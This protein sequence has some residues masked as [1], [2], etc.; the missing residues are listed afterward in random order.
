MKA[1]ATI[2]TAA[3]VTAL[4]PACSL[5]PT[6]KEEVCESFTELGRSFTNANGIFDNAVFRNAGDLADIAGRYNGGDML[7]RDAKAL[8]GIADSKHT[9]GLELLNATQQIAKLCGHQLIR[10]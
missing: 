4:V 8:S 9:N 2:A 5:G 3:L 6:S 1:F 7:Q 10:L